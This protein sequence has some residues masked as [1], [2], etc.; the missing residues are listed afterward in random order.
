MIDFMFC[1]VDK[2]ERLLV[3]TQEVH[4]LLKDIQSQIQEKEI[5][6]PP[7]KKLVRR[8]QKPIETTLISK[9]EIKNETI[10]DANNSKSTK[11][12]KRG[13]Y[14]NWFTAHLWP[15]IL[16]TVK[17]HG[18]LIRVIHYLKTFHR[19]LG[20][21]SGPYEKLI[22]GSLYEWLTP[23]RELIPHMKIVVEKRTTSIVA[24]KHFSILEI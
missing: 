4:A 14:T 5:T 8:P 3:V 7:F 18:D 6:T 15:L 19:K 22:K 9:R 21:V 17:K 11:K 1:R 12:R 23:R 16:T 2:E 10:D 24:K 20:E 13:V